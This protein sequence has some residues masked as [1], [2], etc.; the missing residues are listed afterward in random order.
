MRGTQILVLAAL[1]ATAD[2]CTVIGVTHGASADGSSLLAHTDDAGGGTADTRLVRVPAMDHPANATRDVYN[3]FG[4][5]PRITSMGRGPLYEPVHGQ[6]LMKPLGSIPQV[7]H[8]YAYFDQDYGMM[9][10]ASLSIAESTCPAKTVGWPSDVPYGFNM[11]GIG[12]LTK[13]ALERCDS[14]RCAI[15]TMGDLAVAH[16]FYSEDSGDPKAPMY[17]DSA[18]SLGISDKYGEMW[19]FHVLTG[20]KNASAVWAA[21]RVPDG[22]VTV[23][24]NAF[25]IRQMDLNDTD[26]YLASSNV[27]SFA[28]EMGWYSPADGPFDFT[29]AYSWG[30]VT[31]YAGSLLPLYAGRRLWRVL[32]Y[33][34]PS[35]TLDA[36]LG[37]QPTEVTYPFS[38]KP[39]RPVNLTT[40]FRLMR[41]H[42]EGTPYDMTRGLGAGPF[43]NPIRFDG[44]FFNVS[45]GW[46][47]SISMY[48]TMFAFVLQIQAPSIDVSESLRAT[49]WYCQDSPHGS[50]FVPIAPTQSSLPTSYT[51][52]NQSVFNTD[53][54]WW[55]FNFVNQWSMLRWN[56]INGEV[57]S[58]AT[59]L[60][61]DGIA[62]MASLRRNGTHSA[63]DISTQ[64]NAFASSVVAHW[65]ALAWQLVAKYSCGYIVTG[66]GPGK[67]S[68]P[69]YSRAWLSATEFNGWPGASYT[70][71]AK[72][73][74]IEI[75]T[76]TGETISA[77]DVPHTASRTNFVEVVGY[78]VMGACLALGLHALL[79]Q[80]KR[81]DGYDALQ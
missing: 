61:A 16:G 51:T 41:D 43:G 44:P 63:S 9:N 15:Q 2:A 67:M 21:Q 10:E 50:V 66:E 33:V 14:A 71:P 13:I 76:G 8:T 62:L 72:G 39:D 65:W 80:Q 68:A 29:A 52:G 25:T 74:S 12:E 60:E 40:V 75:S 7:P 57:L 37:W 18:E 48:R 69:G 28:T 30:D 59:R 73:K 11:M 1:A 31:G 4:G 46:E 3:V 49:A 45:G 32:D 26:N 77:K 54:A 38:V 53:S 70:D 22:H 81:R 42:Y 56:S 55:A 24:A 58:H 19:I 34:A 78:M 5:Y 6:A 23:L 17:C 20:P 64:L 36:T 35:L 27:V 79:T 47:R